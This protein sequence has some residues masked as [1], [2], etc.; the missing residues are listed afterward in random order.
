MFLIR[1]KN[2]YMTEANINNKM[3]IKPNINKNQLE[4]IQNRNSK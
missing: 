3:K 1:C 2:N 4:L